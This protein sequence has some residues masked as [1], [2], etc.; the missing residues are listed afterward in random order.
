MKQGSSRSY[1]F[2]EDD[3]YE[4]D[5]SEDAGHAPE[6]ELLAQHGTDKLCILVAASR[7]RLPQAMSSAIY[8][9]RACGVLDPVVGLVLNP[10]SATVEFAVGWLDTS[11][12]GNELVTRLSCFTPARAEL[13]DCS[14][15]SISPGAWPTHVAHAAPSS[16]PT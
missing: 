1:V 12:H 5:G 16:L 14:R 2:P 13:W 4:S 7:S 8:H 15:L 9:R 6:T 10:D 3:A 11:G